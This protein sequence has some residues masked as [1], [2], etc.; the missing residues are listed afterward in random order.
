MRSCVCTAL[1][2][3]AAL[4]LGVP[5][6]S[7]GQSADPAAAVFQIKVVQLLPNGLY[8]TVGQGTGFFIAPS[9]AAVTNSHVVLKALQDPFHYRLIA[10]VGLQGEAEFYGVT[11]DCASTL[12]YDA[13]QE[14]GKAPVTPSKD[15]A[16]IHL[17]PPTT[18][19][20]IWSEFLPTGRQVSLATAH[21]G[22]LPSFPALRVAGSASPGTHVRIIG[23]GTSIRSLEKGTLRGEVARLQRTLDGTEIFRV[24]L[25][26]QV[27]RGYS[28]SPVLDDENQVVGVWTWSDSPNPTSVGDAQS[29]TVLVHPCD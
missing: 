25:E 23:Y 18:P 17:T 5:G 29:N 20:K 3:S 26:D 22:P 16:E 9:G 24:S 4:L 13:S 27:E 7:F 8:L 21:S 6:T 19:M 10:L 14:S 11:I 15:V 1:I 12:S 28:G 2:V